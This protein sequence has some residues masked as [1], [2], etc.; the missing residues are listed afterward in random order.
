MMEILG[1]NVCVRCYKF[2]GTKSYVKG[3]VG[4]V[5]RKKRIKRVLLK[6]NKVGRSMNRELI[7]LRRE[8][9]EL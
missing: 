8:I 7:K 5:K 6:Y 1:E 3:V 2:H 9:V 4:S